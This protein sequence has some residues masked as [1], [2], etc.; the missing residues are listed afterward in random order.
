MAAD[1]EQTPVQSDKQ[2]RPSSVARRGLLAAVATAIAGTSVAGLFLPRFTNVRNPGESLVKTPGPPVSVVEDFQ[3][4]DEPDDV[5]WQ[6]AIDA[7]SA[8]TTEAAIVLGTRQRY[9]FSQTVKL[10]GSTGLVLSGLG[11][12]STVI[13]AA[14]GSGKFSDAFAIGESAPIAQVR[15]I[16]FRDLGFQGGLLNADDIVNDE[17]LPR[18][19]RGEREFSDDHF[20]TAIHVQ[21]NRALRKGKEVQFPV[22]T[23]LDIERVNVIG[24]SGLPL[25]I[26]GVNG[27]V[28]VQDCVFA[29][30]MDVGFTY[31][32]SVLFNR[33]VV[34]WSSD[35]GVSISRGTQNVTCTGN[36]IEGSYASG[37]WLGGFEQTA[38]QNGLAI[39]AAP[40]ADNALV[41]ANS[42]TLS[43][44]NGIWLGGGPQRV[45]VVGNHVVGLRRREISPAEVDKLAA[46]ESN[47]SHGNGLYVDEFSQVDR[48]QQ[49]RDI[50][51]ASNTFSDCEN[52]GVLIHAGVDGAYVS[53]NTILRPGRERS[54]DG[55]F[56]RGAAGRANFGVSV[57]GVTA[58]DLGSGV[59]RVVVQGN[60]IVD[61]RKPTREVGDLASAIMERGIYVNPAATNCVIGQNQVQGA[62]V[63][64]TLTDSPLLPVHNSDELPDAEES[65]NGAMIFDARKRRLLVAYGGKWVVVSTKESP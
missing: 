18:I 23:N 20:T 57:P 12:S 64:Y 45:T 15:D 53:N 31:C 16:K 25:L 7:A 63:P 59:T 35:N 37:I 14:A 42:I 47:S 27:T 58:R 54:Q 38:S 33:N 5:S 46:D 52:G 9:A 19:S 61:D 22:I 41:S 6:R 26:S 24:A 17:G 39:S 32:E 13:S 65:P 8:A 56:V 55:S 50:I 40:G 43:G 10:G 29:W 62:R 1:A 28:S 2:R 48:A 21:G 36:N 44:S 49:A 60:V 51:V 34:R 11:A 3:R 4:E 30:C